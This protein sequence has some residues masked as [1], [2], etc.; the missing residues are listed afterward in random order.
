MNKTQKCISLPDYQLAETLI[1]I[2]C[3][4][5][6][7]KKKKKKKI[8]KIKNKSQFVGIMVTIIFI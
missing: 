7:T 2:F 1:I 8:K 5:E 4:Y 6:R 3:F